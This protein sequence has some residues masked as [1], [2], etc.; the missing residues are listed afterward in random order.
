HHE[1]RAQ[2]LAGW[3]DRGVG[4]GCQRNP[5]L[6]GDPLEVAL[7]ARHPLTQAR[8]AATDD[9]VESVQLLPG[10]WCPCAAHRAHHA[11]CAGTVPAR[12]AT[13]PPAVIRWWIC[14]RPARSISPA[15][16]RGPGKRLTELGR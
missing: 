13:I 6:R 4:M 16:A 12:I 2:A 14:V 3:D 8:A 11:P 10:V 1:Q 5:G 15:S 9:R 7:G